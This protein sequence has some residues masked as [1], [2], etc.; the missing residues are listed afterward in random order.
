V[1]HFPADYF[2]KKHISP[3]T[4]LYDSH[5]P[6][7]R[8]PGSHFPVSHLLA[9]FILGLPV[10]Q[11]ILEDLYPRY[12][13]SILLDDLITNLLV[14]STRAL[15]LRQKLESVSLTIISKEL[16]NFTAASPTLIDICA[17]CEPDSIQMFSQISLPEMNTGLDEPTKF[18]KMT[19][20]RY[21]KSRNFAEITTVL[22]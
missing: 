9:S 22:T 17:T 11:S 7:S 3:K 13:H 4:H 16:T 10:C 12:S 5:V 2:L 15:D 1:N 14:N 21:I 6:E 18:V 20:K 19:M 8:F